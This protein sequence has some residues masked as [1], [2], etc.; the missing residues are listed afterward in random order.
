MFVK[1]LRVDE[2]DSALA[3]QEAKNLNAIWTALENLED[4]LEFLQVC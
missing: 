3:I 1:G 2:K 4:Q